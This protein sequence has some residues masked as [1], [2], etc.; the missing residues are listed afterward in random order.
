MLH[1]PRCDGRG[2]SSERVF[3]VPSLSVQLPEWV[4][5]AYEITT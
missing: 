1:A 2:I 5:V 3:G 4:A